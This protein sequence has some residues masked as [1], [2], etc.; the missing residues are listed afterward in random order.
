MYNEEAPCVLNTSSS[1][2]IGCHGEKTPVDNLTDRTKEIFVLGWSNNSKAYYIKVVDPIAIFQGRIINLGVSCSQPSSDFKEGCLLF[3]LEGNV[4]CPLGSSI[5]SITIPAI[6][7]SVDTSP[8]NPTTT[9]TKKTT[10]STQKSSVIESSTSK[11]KRGAE[12]NGVVIGIAVGCAVG[13]I[14]F[15]SFL[16]LLC[17]RR[18]SK[19]NQ[20]ES[21]PAGQGNGGAGRNTADDNS[22]NCHIYQSM[23]MNTPATAAPLYE[24]MLTPATVPNYQNEQTLEGG[25][26]YESMHNFGSQTESAYEPLKGSDGQNVYER[27]DERRN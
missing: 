5:R 22:G 13:A 14:I 21:N 10:Y 4:T 18:K 20:Q 12:T 3:K 27:L 15:L 17:K 8:S 23:D 9:G 24:N 2:V 11:A 25:T 26:L 19:N 16:V 7:S 1:W 6:S